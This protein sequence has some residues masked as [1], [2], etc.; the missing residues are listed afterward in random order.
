MTKDQLT[1]EF[2]RNLHASRVNMD[3]SRAL[4]FFFFH[5][6]ALP[7]I[8]ANLNKPLVYIQNELLQN[9]I[10]NAGKPY[11]IS[12]ISVI[13]RFLIDICIQYNIEV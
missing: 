12:T 5:P 6:S 7:I 10:T 8:I 4:K 3:S 11:S 13:R 1:L 9:G 2:I